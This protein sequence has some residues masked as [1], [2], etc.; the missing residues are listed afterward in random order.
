VNRH[1]QVNKR[2]FSVREDAEFACRLTESAIGLLAL[3]G[4][5]SSFATS[6]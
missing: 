1:L 5:A 4:L 6:R 2:S 3:D